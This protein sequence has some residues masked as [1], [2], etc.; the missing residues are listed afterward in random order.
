MGKNMDATEKKTYV[1]PDAS[2]E[3]GAALEIHA[4]KTEHMFMSC[5]QT[6]GQNYNINIAN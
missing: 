2:K 6:T 3:V 1:L 4:G 5:H